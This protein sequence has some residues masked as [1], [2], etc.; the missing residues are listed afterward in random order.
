[1]YVCAKG[2]RT[3][4][5]GVGKERELGV[6][7]YELCGLSFVTKFLFALFL[8][9]SDRLLVGVCAGEFQRL[10]CL[11]WEGKPNS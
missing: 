5:M 10:F 1:M 7:F 8:N 9:G 11:V 2:T 4:E 6:R 3:K